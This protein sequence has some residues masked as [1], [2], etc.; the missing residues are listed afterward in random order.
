METFITNVLEIPY[1]NNTLQNL[2]TEKD[3]LGYSENELFCIL[4]KINS[5]KIDIVQSTTNTQNMELRRRIVSKKND[6]MV[7]LYL[8]DVWERIHG[9]TY[10]GTGTEWNSFC[11]KFTELLM[12]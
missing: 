2:I 4:I 9:N 12:Q 7:L 6:R 5:Q 1:D 3:L 11:T 8:V 10:L